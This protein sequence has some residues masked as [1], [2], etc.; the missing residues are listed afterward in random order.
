MGLNVESVLNVLKPEGPL[1]ICLKGFEPRP[2][3]LAMLRNVLEAF[4]QK[5]ICLIEAGTGTG[6]SLAYLLPALLW[7]AECKERTV[8]ST[9]TIP[10]QEQLLKKD[11]PMITQ[12]L[13]LDLQAVIVKGMQNYLCLKKFADMQFEQVYLSPKELQEWQK[14][15]SW[16]EGTQEGSR[17]S[18]PFP[19]SNTVW[20]KVAAES[21]LC[22]KSQCPFYTQCHFFKARQQMQHAQLLIVNHHLLFTDLVQRAQS[23]DPNK[24]GGLLPAYG[25]VV[26]DEA[27]HIED[28]ATE[29][30]A[31]NI[32]QLHILRTMGR[33]SSEK[34]GKVHGHL[35]QLREKIASNYSRGMDKSARSL[36]QKLSIDLP[37]LRNE[38]IKE[39]HEAFDTFCSFVK[40]LKQNQPQQMEESA[41][42]KMRLFPHHQKQDVWQTAVTASVKK[43]AASLISFATALTAVLQDL[44][45]L[46]NPTLEDQT[47][48]T[49]FEINSLRTRLE[50]YA[51][52]LTNFLSDFSEADKVRWIQMQQLK[53]MIVTTLVD[54]D[55]DI[56]PFLIDYLFSKFATIVL[57][58]ATLTA[59][60]QFDFYKQRLGLSHQK[61]AGKQIEM[62][63]YASPFDF[64][65]Q[66][67]FLD[68]TDIPEPTSP[69]F[70]TSACEAIVQA[71]RM[72]QG[73][74]FVLFTSNS[75]LN[76]MFECLEKRLV[77]LRLVPL[78]QGE[79][80]RKQLLDKFK[81]TE[82]SV[83]FATSSF[84]EGIDVAGD[85]LRCVII[86]KLPFKVPSDPLIQA[87]SEQIAKK[88]GEP[89][90]EYLLPQAIVKFKQGCGRLIRAKSDRGCILCLDSRIRTKKYGKLFLDSLPDCE[91]AFVTQAE[92]P[93][94]MKEFY[95]KTHFLVAGTR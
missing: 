18:I 49:V 13:R 46:K 39:A 59:N 74:A 9:H 33:L 67:L 56:S 78:R 55:L 19:L 6:K 95:R 52:Q 43:L 41:D 89:F 86:V 10:L 25:R 66:Q 77:D 17:S 34:S 88:G 65:K 20:E 11:I 94:V 22:S 38:L 23:K 58:S 90:S 14:L 37:G 92:L 26:I 2:A 79:E 42:N 60:R 27:H 36:H 3:Q 8:I 80:D 51:L 87:R 4:N 64:K 40:S 63:T 57:C 1:S 48:A 15:V 32:S 24:E 54:A 16:K 61:L 44:K 82:R 70:I 84:W 30:F 12:A 73:N 69:H 83:L 72:S 7:A 76:S 50:E 35:P 68:P 85:A 62:H 31:S 91:T 5:K 29:Y 71:V 21:D 81:A 75:M 28:I 53:T 93:T 47:R 45:L